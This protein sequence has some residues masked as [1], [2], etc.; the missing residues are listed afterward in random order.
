MNQAAGKR[1]GRGAEGKRLRERGVRGV[2]ERDRGERKKE[3]SRERKKEMGCENK[4][5]S[6]RERDR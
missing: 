3:S 5:Y 1:V 4:S 6:K 2:R